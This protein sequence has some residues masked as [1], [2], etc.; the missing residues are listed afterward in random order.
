[1][2]YFLL[3]GDEIIVEIDTGFEQMN[4]QCPDD[5]ILLSIKYGAYYHCPVCDRQY[6]VKDGVI[7]F[8]A[9][10]DAFYE[11]AYTNQIFFI[12]RGRSFWSELPLWII[13]NGYLWNVRRYVPRGSWVVDMGCAAGVDWFGKS[14]SMIGVDV[15]HSGLAIAA[16]KYHYCLQAADLA[17]IPDASLDA[18][19]TSYFWEHVPSDVKEKLTAEFMRVL[20]PGGHIVFVYDVET[21]NPL[22]VWIRGRRS[23][24][25]NKLFIDGDGHLG[26]EPIGVNEQRFERHGFELIRSNPMERT[27]L[28]STSVYKKMEQWEG[29]PRIV[30]QLSKFLDWGPVAKPYWVLLRIIDE[31]VGR[32]LPREWGRITLTV[33]KKPGAR[34]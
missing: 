33:A 13:T 26:Y 32:L 27:L 2:S 22:I 8:L 12:P 3:N 24:L 7:R 5:K 10:N 21:K 25:Y 18:V 30:A 1:M 17:A 31:T 28:Q 9:E 14:Y 16:R 11:G 20:K 19:V 23:D 4:L 15:S 29:T 6:A 34:K